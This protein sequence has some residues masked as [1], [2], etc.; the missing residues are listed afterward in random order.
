MEFIEHQVDEQEKAAEKTHYALPPGVRVRKERFGLLFYNSRDA[1]LTFVRSGDLL[2]VLVDPK[3][4]FKL[5]AIYA[6]AE[7][8]R[9]LRLLTALAKKGLIDEA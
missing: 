1:K 8:E 7:K 6:T 9:T 4:N 5:T 3:R 2:E